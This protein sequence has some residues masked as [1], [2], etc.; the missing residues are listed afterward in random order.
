M[1]NPTRNAAQ[2]AREPDDAGADERDDAHAG[3]T[4]AVSSLRDE[5]VTSVPG[6]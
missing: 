1:P 6:A 3:W 4:G 5:P 2:P